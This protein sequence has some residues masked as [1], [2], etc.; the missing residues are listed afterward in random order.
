[1][2]GFWD[3]V[4]ANVGPVE[5]EDRDLDFADVDMSPAVEAC[6][7]MPFGGNDETSLHDLTDAARRAAAIDPNQNAGTRVRFIANVGS[8]LSYDDPPADKLE[9]MVVAVKTGSGVTTHMD[10]RLFVLWDDGKFRDIKAEHL[11]LARGS[12]RAS[13]VRMVVADLGDISSFFSPVAS[14]TGSAGDELVHMSTKDLWAV[15]QEG[16]NFVIE[17]LFDT[18]GNPLKV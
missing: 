18:T 12:K 8:I 4:I 14:I 2:G 16:G 5:G 7:G 15:K 1:M 13:N 10:D 6:Q 17:R 11:R 9:G 3:E